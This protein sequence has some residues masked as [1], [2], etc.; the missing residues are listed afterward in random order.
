MHEVRGRRKAEQPRGFADS[1]RCQ[2]V[3]TARRQLGGAV[4]D[5]PDDAIGQQAG[6]GAVDRRVRLAQNA[7]QLC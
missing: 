5:A 7:C 2:E 4:T 1:L 3:P 6:Q